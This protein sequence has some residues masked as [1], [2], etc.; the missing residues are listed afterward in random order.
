[1]IHPP[2][3]HYLRMEMYSSGVVEVEV[4]R[5]EYL[6]GVAAGLVDLGRME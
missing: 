4:Q 3:L 6:P 5:M 2:S 1:M